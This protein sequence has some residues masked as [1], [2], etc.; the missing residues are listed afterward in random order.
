MFTRINRP[1]R[2]VFPLIT[3]EK[4]LQQKKYNLVAPLFASRLHFGV[5]N[6]LHGVFPSVTQTHLRT[7]HSCKNCYSSSALVASHEVSFTT[8]ADLIEGACKSFPKNDVFGTRNG[9][10]F[11]YIKYEDFYRLYSASRTMLFHKY[12]VAEGDKVAMISN[13]RVEWATLMYATVSLGAQWVPM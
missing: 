13:N 5:G 1:S 3:S 4:Q 10:K 7:F 6:Y 2:R 9:D 11:D 12:G 8:L